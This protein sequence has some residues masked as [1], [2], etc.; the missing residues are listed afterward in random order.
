M[1]KSH[2]SGYNDNNVNR[3]N[4]PSNIIPS[5]NGGV[6]GNPFGQFNGISS[7]SMMQSGYNFNA[8]YA[9]NQP[10]IDRIDYNNKGNLLHNNVG[11]TVLS[12]QITEYRVNID[13]LDRDINDF[14]NP[15]EFVVRYTPMSAGRVNSNNWIRGNYIADRQYFPGTPGPGINKK[16]EKVKYIRLET[17][18]LPQYSKIV[19]CE[20]EEDDDEDIE[21]C[22]C[23]EEEI[24]YVYDP[25]SYL[26]DD[27]FVQ[28][29]INELNNNTQI[30]STSDNGIRIDPSTG[31]DI[32]VPRIFTIIYPDTI[33]GKRYYL[34]TP[35]NAQ[36]NYD[37]SGLGEVNR[38]TIKFYD[39]CGNPL[40][41]ENLYTAQELKEASENGCPIPI[42]DIR[43]PLNKNN[44]VY[45]S[46]TIGVVEPKIN[47][48]VQL[49]K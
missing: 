45:I 33:V 10:M 24:E 48:D 12:E 5:N 35:Y 11:E 20:E 3:S 31:K 15:F 37:T 39:S 26:P 14:L 40:N 16:F 38:M 23:S 8:A 44:Q 36:K 1:R 4:M 34:G 47:T 22:E 9:L 46:L 19:P 6:N 42:T 29:S 41:F 25:C 49:S 17:I 30:Y 13:S 7:N 2:P 21:E 28:M 32:P 27:R 18:I 43:H